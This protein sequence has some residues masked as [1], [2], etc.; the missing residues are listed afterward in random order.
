MTAATVLWKA[1]ND[2][3]LLE[4]PTVFCTLALL[5]VEVDGVGS[6]PKTRI[7]VTE[8]PDTR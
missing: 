2:Y 8:H 1:D 4:Q 7:T 5:G 6:L 3:H